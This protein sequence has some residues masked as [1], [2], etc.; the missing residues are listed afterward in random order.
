MRPAS[1]R[2][3]RAIQDI[4]EPGSTFKLV[5]TSAA[6]E[7]GVARRDELFDVSAGVIRVGGS[8]FSDMH[9]YGVLSLDDVIVKSSNVGA[10]KIGLRLGPERLSRYVRRFG[11]GESLSRDLPGESP[12][13]VHKPATLGD[14]GVAS[15]SIG[16]S[17]AVTPLQMA[18]AASAV[19]NGGELLEPRAVRAV[20]HDGVREETPRR[21]IRR[22]ISA[23]TAAELTSI[24]EAVVERGTGRAARLSGYTV[25]GKTGTTE[26]LI[27]GRYSNVDHNAS[28]V[29]FVPSREPALTILVMIDT[30]RGGAFTGGGVA[31]PVFRRIAEAAL[32]HLAV[33]PTVNPNPPILVRPAVA[34]RVARVS[35]RPRS[36]AV[37]TQTDGA[38]PEH[39][40]MP[41]LR[42]MSAREAL[43]KLGPL[44]LSARLEGN[45][46]VVNQE[47]GPGVPVDRGT[48]A[49]LDLERQPRRLADGGR[50]LGR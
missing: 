26:K 12:G 25:A 24:M 34:P 7:E 1:A 18:A 27:D 17:V 49:M 5:T 22:A 45:G 3:N 31:A 43:G 6:L 41:D 40:L 48:T 11:F 14:G 46:F 36:R 21:V 30:P 33:P 23:E 38:S 19:A 13:I 4:Y 2:R 16:Y 37:L 8:E 42:G 10:I 44:R 39:G 29:G 15:I 20:I 28:F 35:T 32:R 47:P 9:R 50:R